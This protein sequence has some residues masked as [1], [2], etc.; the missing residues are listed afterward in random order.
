MEA[1]IAIFVAE[2]SRINTNL[3]D[4]LRFLYFV[5]INDDEQQLQ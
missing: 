4:W 1:S 5:D 2:D 3:Q